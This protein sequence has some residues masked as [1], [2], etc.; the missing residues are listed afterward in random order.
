MACQSTN[1]CTD[2]SPTSRAPA[3]QTM[4]IAKE[5]RAPVESPSCRL[6][7]WKCKYPSQDGNLILLQ[8]KPANNECTRCTPRSHSPARAAASAWAPELTASGR[9]P[10]QEWQKREPSRYSVPHRGQ[11][12]AIA[13]A[14]C[15]TSASCSS[16]SDGGRQ[17]SCCVLC[18]TSDIA[19]PTRNPLRAL[20]APNSTIH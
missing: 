12:S 2:S 14:A 4:P 10:P 8:E 6:I 7:S 9:R 11:D 13:G 19:R 1:F 20:Q 5:M 18:A 3:T 15:R 17:N 16:W